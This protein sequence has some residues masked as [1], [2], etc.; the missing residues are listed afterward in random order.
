MKISRLGVISTVF[1]NMRFLLASPVMKGLYATVLLVSSAGAQANFVI[2]DV[3]PDYSHQTITIVGTSFSPAPTVTLANIPLVAQ[4]VK[5][6]QI[7]AALPTSYSPGTYQL[8]VVSGGQSQ[9]FL[10][11]LGAVG[12]PGPQGPQGPAGSSNVYITRQADNEVQM[13]S[14]PGGTTP[15]TLATLNLPSGSYSLDGRVRLQLDGQANKNFATFAT[16]E[17]LDSGTVIDQVDFA[18]AEILTSDTVNNTFPMGQIVSL[19]GTVTLTSG[20]PITLQCTLSGNTWVTAYA[21]WG[22]LKATQVVQI[23]HQ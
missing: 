20:G 6:T 15:A 2:N 21:R 18:L 22:V 4:R 12:P 14:G 23:T 17:L 19:T 13:S 11:S 5:S 10:V 1:A 3:V 9:N 16:C 8:T 7:V